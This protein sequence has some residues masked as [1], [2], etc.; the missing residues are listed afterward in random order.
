MQN[1]ELKKFNYL[2]LKNDFKQQTYS[3]SKNDV[4]FRWIPAFNKK[5]L[6]LKPVP[7]LF[8]KSD[9]DLINRSKEYCFV[10]ENQWLLKGIN[11][12]KYKEDRLGLLLHKMIHKWFSYYLDKNIYTGWFHGKP[13]RE[14]IK[15]FGIV[16]DEKGNHLVYTNPFRRFVQETNPEDYTQF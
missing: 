8:Y 3:G 10:T 11:Y 6:N 5:F 15:S 2:W 12:Q 9:S 13:F 7:T 4:F 1:F 14:L 16:C